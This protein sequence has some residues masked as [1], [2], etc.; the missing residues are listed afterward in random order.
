MNAQLPKSHL[1]LPLDLPIMETNHTFASG[2]IW[3]TQKMS[4]RIATFD[5]VIREMPPHRNFLLFGGLEEIVQDLKNWRYTPGHIRY[6]SSVGVLNNRMKK[7]LRHYR[8]SGDVWAM[9]EGTVF[10]PGEPVLRIRAPLIEANLFT[11]YFLNVVTSHTIFLSKAIRSVLAAP[12]KE[13]LGGSARAQSIETNAKAVRA[14]YIA[15]G[16]VPSST[17]AICYKYN[18][19]LLGAPTFFGQ[20]AFIKSFDSELDGMRAFA[21]AFPDQTAFMIDTYDIKRGLERAIQVALDLKKSGHKLRFI[22]IDSGDLEKLSKLAR[23]KLDD[24]ELDYVKIIVASNLDEYKLKKLISARTPA[25]VFVVIT[26]LNT[27]SDAPKL[28][29]VYKMAQLENKDEV[30]YTAKLTPGK[31]S[32]P[33]VKQVYRTYRNGVIMHDYIGLAH[34][35]LGTPLLEP[36]FKSG[37][38]V[39]KLPTLEHIRAYIKRQVRTLPKNLQSIN[40]EYDF[41][42]RISPSLQ[43]LIRRVRVQHLA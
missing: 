6:L 37:K 21:K 34:E 32:L 9:R 23:K 14:L 30:K 3:F 27:S 33:G 41:H 40:R 31:S 26:E 39:Y 25:D 15:G 20:H 18:I 2:S 13:I 29:I 22:V 28:E 35:R 36:V 38:L 10:F 7:Y 5:L 4:K 24:A 1:Y 17:A 8:F 42:P 16:G 12:N 43:Q 11:L 19:P